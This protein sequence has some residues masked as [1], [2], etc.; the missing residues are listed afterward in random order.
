MI[1]AIIN[2]KESPL[3]DI[4]RDLIRQLDEFPDDRGI[5][6]FRDILVKSRG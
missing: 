5:D 4:P 1:D 6:L 3:N 2:G